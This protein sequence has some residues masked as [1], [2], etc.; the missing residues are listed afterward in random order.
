MKSKKKMLCLSKQ[1]FVIYI[2]DKF[3]YIN[4]DKFLKEKTDISYMPFVY[5]KD[6]DVRDYGFDITNCK[7]KMNNYMMKKLNHL[8]RWKPNMNLATNYCISNS[9]KLFSAL[10]IT[11]NN[12][13]PEKYSNNMIFPDNI[14]NLELI[15]IIKIKNII[16]VRNKTFSYI[17]F[18]IFYDTLINKCIIYTDKGR[19]V[20][21]PSITEYFTVTHRELYNITQIYNVTMYQSIDIPELFLISPSHHLMHIPNILNNIEASDEKNNNKTLYDV[22]KK[23]F[24]RVRVFRTKPEN[25]LVMTDNN[26]ILLKYPKNDYH[27]K[28]FK[29]QFDRPFY[30]RNVIT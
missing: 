7:W 22:F 20:N 14:K 29:E 11:Q 26:L 6:I 8:I 21:I 10:F 27:S 9:L 5:G 16:S 4:T 12:D 17:F 18:Y 2:V 24:R 23:Q 30:S 1:I 3:M 13:I 15:N 25:S 19:T 28:I